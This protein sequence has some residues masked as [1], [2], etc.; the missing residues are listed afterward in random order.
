MLIESF[1]T[2]LTGGHPNSLGRTIEVVDIVLANRERLQELYACYFSADEVVRLR[3]SNALKRVSREHPEWL[4]PYIDKFIN[5]I[6]KIDQA[7]TQWTLA[8][9]FQGLESY[10]TA[11]QKLKATGIMKRN[12]EFHKDWIVL[13]N[14]MATLAEWSNSDDALKQWLKP[15]LERLRHDRRKSVSGKAKKLLAKL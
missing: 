5:E 12:L 13:N 14:T 4:V 11:D 10:M 15:Q 6:S 2:M 1:E 3:T 7:S 8:L 9:L